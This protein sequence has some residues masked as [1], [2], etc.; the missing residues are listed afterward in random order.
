MKRPQINLWENI[1]VALTALRTN[2]MRSILTTLGIVIGVAAVIIMVALGNAARQ[3]VVADIES[4]GTNN[5]VVGPPPQMHGARA[6]ATYQLTER[7]GRAIQASVPG[8]DMV[9]PQVRATVSAIYENQNSTTTLIGSTPDYARI[10]D[11]DLVS[12]RMYSDTEMAGAAKVAVVGDK[13]REDLFGD[14]DPVGMT[15]R[16][17]RTPLLIIGLLEKKG[18]GGLGPDLDDVVLVPINTARRRMGGLVQ[19]PPDAIQSMQIRFASTDELARGIEDI[20]TLMRKRSN[21]QEGDLDPFRIFSPE[22]LLQSVGRVLGIFQL[23]LA[24]IASISLLVGGIGI[25]NIMLVSVTERTREIG[26][27]MAMGARPRDVQRQFLIEAIVL[28]VIG[29]LIGL[30]LGLLA[31]FGMRAGLDWPAAVSIGT[32]MLAVTVSAI[33]GVAFGFFPARKASRMNPIEALRHE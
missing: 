29:G 6:S 28:C 8:V 14:V 31:T 9:V 26:L 33:I 32:A 4:F 21:T 3:L 12:G 11:W 24:G 22:E 5:I 15:I 16:V 23:V 2:T 25:M 27:R 7:D 10:A 18:Q 13:I 17:N 20:T 30:T 19:G 1:R